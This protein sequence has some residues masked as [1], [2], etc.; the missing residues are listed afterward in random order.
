MK[1]IHLTDTHFGLNDQKIYGRVPKHAFDAAIT[2]VNQ[3]H[4]DADCVIIT[5]D[6]AHWG[7]KEAYISLKESLEKLQLPYHL[8]IGN[9]D[10]RDTLREIFPEL[11]LNEDGFVQYTFEQGGNVFIVM[12]SVQQGTHAGE[13]CEK[14]LQWLDSALDKAD[15]P[16]F[17]L[18]HHAPFA[19]GI[20]SMDVIGFSEGNKQAIAK[21]LKRHDKVKHLFFGHYHRPI[22]GTWQGIG[23][24]TL[25]S[26]NH[27]VA[28]DMH[29]TDV[30]NA[31]FE[32]PTYNVV[33]IDNELVIVH[34][35]DFT[36]TTD[37]FSLGGPFDDE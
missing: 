11:P 3:Y 28:L 5:G 18:M 1:L 26:M 14:R 34:T 29:T 25:K 15:K 10:D 21:M 35:R 16:V 17:L 31:S 8:V 4:S 23:F 20:P 12:D 22:N 30:I 37:T 9:H 19:V 27:Q 32:S 6:L 33:L 7:E 2:D 13:F 24:S 36:D